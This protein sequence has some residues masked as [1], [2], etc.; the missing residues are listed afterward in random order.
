MCDMVRPVVTQL[1]SL[2]LMS[3]YQFTNMH[4]VRTD[5]QDAIQAAIEGRYD[6]WLKTENDKVPLEVLD[7]D[8]EQTR[9]RTQTQYDRHLHL[10]MFVCVLSIRDHSHAA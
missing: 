5:A 10:S 4:D 7:S 1:L 9:L 3:V 2:V 6:V 8:D